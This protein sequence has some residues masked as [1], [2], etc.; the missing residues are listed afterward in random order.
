M[1][2]YWSSQWRRVYFEI[3]LIFVYDSHFSSSTKLLLVD[4]LLKK[5]WSNSVIR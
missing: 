1:S 3:N 4:Q 2:Q 5:F